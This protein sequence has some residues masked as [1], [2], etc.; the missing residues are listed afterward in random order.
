MSNTAI[1]WEQALQII[2]ILAAAFVAV[3]ALILIGRWHMDKTQADSSLVR[4]WMALFLVVGLLVFTVA[5]MTF[6]DATVRNTL[7]GAVAANAGAAIAFYFASKSS[8]QA[9]QDILSATFG[10]GQEEVPDLKDKTRDE[11][12]KL[13]LEHSL[14]LKV[15]PASSQDKLATVKHQLPS[16]HTTVRRGTEVL[17]DLG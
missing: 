3:G 15:D 10:I 9:R 7:I 4:S 17:V 2:G 12:A 14:L 5:S 11:A 6:D 16:G 1:A 8:D 13:L